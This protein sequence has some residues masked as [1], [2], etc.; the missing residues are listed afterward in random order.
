MQLQATLKTNTGKVIADLDTFGGHATIQRGPAMPI[1]VWEGLQSLGAC[2][3][4]WILVSGPE[5]AIGLIE[6]ISESV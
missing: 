5:S 4:D 3:G 2:C 1:E 6:R